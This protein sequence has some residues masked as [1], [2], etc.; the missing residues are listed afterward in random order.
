[1]CDNNVQANHFPIAASHLP[2]GPVPLAYKRFPSSFSFKCII[3]QFF[4]MS[5]WS[6]GNCLAR[7]N[8][9]RTVQASII[10]Y[11]RKVLPSQKMT[12]REYVDVYAFGQS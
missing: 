10:T 11:V 5:K 6:N 8:N 3:F 1:M 7:E 9:D 12:S 4:S 2:V